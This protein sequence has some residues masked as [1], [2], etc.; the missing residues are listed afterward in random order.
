MIELSEKLASAWGLP[1][2]V[3]SSVFAER[4]G[5][6]QAPVYF[7]SAMHQFPDDLPLPQAVAWSRDAIASPYTEAYYALELS[8]QQRIEAFAAQ[9]RTAAWLE[10]LKEWQQNYPDLPMLYNLELAYYRAQEDFES[11]EQRAQEILQRFPRYIF[12]VC[13]LASLYLYTHRPEKA[14]ALFQGA[15]EIQAFT[16][17]QGV[18]QA[19][20]MSSFYSVMAWLHL[21]RLRVL[22]AAFCF[23]LVYEIDAQAPFLGQLVRL[24]A[25]L[26]EDVLLQLRLVLNKSR[27]L[28]PAHWLEEMGLNSVG[29]SEA[30]A[31]D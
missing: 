27:E 30:S 24:F 22:R 9:K 2:S 19:A 1:Q 15:Y 10:S 23:A 7:L 31:G 20:E 26:P 13:S 25:H 21:V 29:P 16:A 11:W 14:E 18:F 5:L 6:K 17:E 3:E 4:L 8:E 12:A 28:T